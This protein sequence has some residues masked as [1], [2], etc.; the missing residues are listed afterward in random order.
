MI[1][2]KKGNIIV[3]HY[4]TRGIIYFDSKKSKLE[5]IPGYFNKQ[6]LK[7]IVKYLDSF[8]EQS[9]AISFKPDKKSKIS[10]LIISPYKKSDVALAVCG[11]TLP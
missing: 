7:E 10:L 9:V 6:Y 4:G 5:E 8:E 2:I 11:R 3:N 1:P